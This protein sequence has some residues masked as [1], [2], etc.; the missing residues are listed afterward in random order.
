MYVKLIDL[1]DQKG[2]IYTDQTGNLPVRARSG[3]RF[4]MVMVAIDSNAIL[5]TPVKDHTDQQLRNA[6]LTL[7]KRVKNAGVKVKKHI[8]DIECSNAMKEVIKQ[9]CELELVPP[10]CH[11]RNIAEIGIKIF[12]N[13]LISIL[14]GVDSSFPMSLWD[15]LLPQAELT[16]NL[17]RQSNSTPNVSAHAHL[18]GVFDFNKMPLAPLGCAIQ[19]HEDPDKRA[20]LAP[21]TIDSWY[22][23]HC[24]NITAPT[25]CM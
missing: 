8:L 7:L 18:F 5:V 14:E 22:L 13:H 9:E 3:N 2:T 17:L 21:H 23:G 6:Y 10:G 19:I 16:I 11:R 1:W 15:K 20:S 25:G 24:L 4:I 12:K